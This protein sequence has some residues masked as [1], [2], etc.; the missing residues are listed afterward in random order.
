MTNEPHQT[1]ELQLKNREKLTVSDVQEVGSFDE[2]TI[3]LVTGHGLLI[4]RGENLQLKS[5]S[6][7]G[8]QVCVSGLVHSLDYE[9]NK[10]SGFF[11]RL[12]G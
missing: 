5:L 2:N 3:A 4:I 12:F 8:G 10:K 7:D 9:E 1:H 6:I 11:K